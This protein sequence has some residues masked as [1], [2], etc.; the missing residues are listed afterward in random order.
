MKVVFNAPLARKRRRQATLL[1]MGGIAILFLGL[2]FNFQPSRQLL[3]YAYMCLILGSLMSWL[4]V[5]MADLWL[6]PPRAEVVMGEAMKGAARSFALYHWALPADHVLLAPW[7]LTLFR[8]FNI[9]GA[10]DIRGERWRDARPLTRKL[11]SLGR[12]PVRNPERILSVEADQLRQALVAVDPTLS[13]VPMQLAGLFTHDGVRLAVEDPNLP[14][15]RVDELREWLRTES[16]KPNLEPLERRALEAAL[17]E[18][19]AQRMG[20]AKAAAAQ[21]KAEEAAQARA[22]EKAAR[23]AKTKAEERAEKRARARERSA[24]QPKGRG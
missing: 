9:E 3:L 23:K 11:F 1:S 7:G 2:Y 15:V 22:A 12:Q 16:K 10:V 24:E 19:A 8:V 14:V 5:S 4:G 17:D 21:A 18:V 13:G 20:T 6:R